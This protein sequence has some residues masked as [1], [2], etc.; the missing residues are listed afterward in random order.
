MV[1]KKPPV[2]TTNNE[3]P[4]KKKKKKWVNPHKREYGIE[5]CYNPNNKDKTILH[6]LSIDIGFATS[7]LTWLD[8]STAK[9]TSLYYKKDKEC[10][11]KGMRIVDL[12]H[13]CQDTLDKYI[14]LIPE[15]VLDCLDRT[16]II[17]EEPLV[18][19]GQKSFSISLYVLLGNLIEKFIKDYNVHSVCLVT[20]GSAKRL[21]GVKSNVKM[22]DS[23]KTKFLKD[24]LPEWGSKNNHIADSNFSMILT[25]QEFLKQNYPAL[26]LLKDV[27][28]K[29]YESIF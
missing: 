2:E 26:E 10:K 22:P 4:S 23:E 9:I 19:A 17:L 18:V 15:S 16:Q 3:N 6:K 1:K 20:P 12:I 14:E 21:L 13:L 27:S 25:N 28:Y 5:V 8:M 29:V 11:V 7:G 24:N